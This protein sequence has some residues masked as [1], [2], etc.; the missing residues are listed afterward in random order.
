MIINCSVCRKTSANIMKSVKTTYFER[1][2]K[3][4][5]TF[6]LE[7]DFVDRL[8]QAFSKQQQQQQTGPVEERLDLFCVLTNGKLRPCLISDHQNGPQQ[9]CLLFTEE[10]SHHWKNSKAGTIIFCHCREAIALSR[11]LCQV[12][13]Q[14]IFNSIVL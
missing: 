6:R 11:R 3:E 14:V 9:N 2:Q 5:G 13:S 8:V 10:V 1:S 4:V 7:I 12:T